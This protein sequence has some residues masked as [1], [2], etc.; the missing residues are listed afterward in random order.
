MKELVGKIG[1]PRKLT[2][3]IIFVA[4]LWI[5][6]SVGRFVLGYLSAI[7]PGGLLDVEVSQVTIQMTNAMF[8]LPVVKRR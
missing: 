3:G 5:I 8:F 2:K 1:I 6:Q 7:T 4:L